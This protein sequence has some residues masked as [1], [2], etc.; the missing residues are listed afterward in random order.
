MATTPIDPTD[1][2]TPAHE[3]TCPSCGSPWRCFCGLDPC[4][5][6]GKV[7]DDCQLAHLARCE[8]CQL[9]NHTGTNGS[10]G[11]AGDDC[12]CPCRTS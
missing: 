6:A 2:T 8:P 7:C 9:G 3:L 12:T 4:L 10:R 1:V 5:F 11:C